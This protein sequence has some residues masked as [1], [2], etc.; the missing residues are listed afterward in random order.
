MGAFRDYIGIPIE[1][2]PLNL[3]YYYPTA[4]SW[5]DRHV[6]QCIVYGSTPDE[7]FR[8]SL[9][10]VARVSVFVRILVARATRIRTE[11]IGQAAL[12]S[13]RTCCQRSGSLLY[14]A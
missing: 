3:V 2:T 11:T 7:Y 5:A 12:M 10:G 8:T 6:V 9:L 14:G 1:R 13:A 4:G